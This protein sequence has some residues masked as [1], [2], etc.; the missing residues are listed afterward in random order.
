VFP[1]YDYRGVPEHDYTAICNILQRTLRDK[2]KR[3]H[4]SSDIKEII[5]SGNL[6]VVRVV[7]TLTA[8]PT[9]MSGKAKVSKEFSLDVLKKQADKSWRMIRFVAYEVPSRD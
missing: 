6:A 5:V 7:W 8:T 4:Y 1:S 2:T 3:Y 9:K